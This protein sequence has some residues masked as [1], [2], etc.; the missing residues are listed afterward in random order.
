[1]LV[2]RRFHG[3]LNLR[4]GHMIAPIFTRRLDKGK[5]LGREEP[6]TDERPYCIVALYIKE[7]TPCRQQ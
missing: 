5:L 4:I 7:M 6:L 2:R 1:M 3:F